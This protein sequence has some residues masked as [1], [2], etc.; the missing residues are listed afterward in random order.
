[1]DLELASLAIRLAYSTIF[2]RG[3]CLLG[4]RRGV[5][6]S[7]FSCVS[8]CPSVQA[9]KASTALSCSFGLR[10]G[11]AIGLRRTAL[12]GAG[13]RWAQEAWYLSC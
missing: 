11:W 13:G 10:R 5:S 8:R 1:M 7:R 12:E 3:V 6:L 4:V 2:S 9:L